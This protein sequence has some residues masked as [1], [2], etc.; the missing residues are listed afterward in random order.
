MLLLTENADIQWLVDT[1]TDN[2]EWRPLEELN[3]G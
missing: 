3:L 1:A 2:I